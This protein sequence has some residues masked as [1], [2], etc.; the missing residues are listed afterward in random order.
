[1]K[2]LLLEIINEAKDGKVIIDSETWPICFNTLLKIDRYKKEDYINIMRDKVVI[3]D[4]N[5]Y[6]AG[7]VFSE[8]YRHELLQ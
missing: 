4:I 2:D 1:M 3:K 8:N 5:G 6:K 7:I